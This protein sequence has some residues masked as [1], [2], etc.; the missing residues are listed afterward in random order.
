M[1][2]HDVVS[3]ESGCSNFIKVSLGG[4]SLTVKVEA[5]MP[6]GEVDLEGES[7]V[8]LDRVLGGSEAESVA[9]GS[10][11]V[12]R[13][14]SREALDG[15]GC[16]VGARVAEDEFVSH[17]SRSGILVDVHPML[18][19]LA[20]A[21]DGGSLDAFSGDEVDLVRSRDDLIKGNALESLDLLLLGA[22]L[23]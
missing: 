5:D 1:Q 10:L 20:E 15:E 18:L 14:R 3:G 11:S 21:L 6:V 12:S 4:T 17:R 2:L 19:P 16:N 23:V 22:R 13:W 8:V 7:Q 9:K